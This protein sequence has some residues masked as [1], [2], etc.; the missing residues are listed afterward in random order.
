MR[1]GGRRAW[2]VGLMHAGARPLGYV[3]LRG[4][5]ILV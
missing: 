4:Y 3:M 5:I 2:R 1:A